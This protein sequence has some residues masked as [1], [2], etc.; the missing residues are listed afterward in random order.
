MPRGQRKIEAGAESATRADEIRAN[1]RMRA[2]SVVASGIKLAVDEDKLDRDTYEYRFVNDK[3]GR[4]QRLYDQD[5]DFVT[6]DAK[7]DSNS[8]GSLATAHAGVVDGKPFN[9]VLM[10]KH[11][12]LYKDD[13]KAKMQPLAEMDQAI[14]RGADHKA[15]ELRGDGVYTPNGV[16]IIER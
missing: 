1:R 8:V 16:N 5:W 3:D 2:G 12:V 13:Q 6:D 4:P 11:K 7:P 10:K 9:A 14:R 15:N